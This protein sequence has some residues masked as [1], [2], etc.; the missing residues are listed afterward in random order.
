MSAR[1]QIKKENDI[2]NKQKSL[3]TGFNIAVPQQ[4]AQRR[5]TIQ[6][7]PVPE[8]LKR[9]ES[10]PQEEDQNFSSAGDRGDQNS[11]NESSMNTDQKNHNDQTEST[12]RQDEKDNVE[13]QQQLNDTVQH[14]IVAAYVT[15]YLNQHYVVYLTNHFFLDGSHVLPY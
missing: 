12:T 13:V 2:N 1:F 6:N 5:D 7:L 3:K 10:V 11:L 4:P 9:S 15:G 8:E 14:V